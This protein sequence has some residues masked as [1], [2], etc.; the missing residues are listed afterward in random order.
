LSALC[1][2]FPA[3]LALI[4]LAV[5]P[6]GAQPPPPE[7]GGGPSAALEDDRHALELE[8]LR[9]Q[10]RTRGLEIE[11]QQRDASARRW[12]FGLLLCAAALAALAL[13]WRRQHARRLSELIQADPLTGLVN[14]RTIFERLE[15]LLA[16]LAEDRGDAA[17]LLIDLDNFRS[18]ND[19][20]GHPVG[21]VVLQSVGAALRAALRPGDEV[22]RLGGEEFM[23]VLPRTDA[24]SAMS[25][26]WRLHECLQDLPE[27]ADGGRS[28]SVTAS[29]GVASTRGR[30]TGVDALY[31]ATEEALL[32]AKDGGGNRC[33]LASPRA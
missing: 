8:L 20:Y 22:A 16:R 13:Y 9:E 19:R 30:P 18:V 26:A 24:A 4:V 17:V 25:V 32:R 27:R 33:E 10:A 5:V 7:S 21:D 28:I 2:F 3:L 23:I 11:L 14:R 15:A 29:I 6:A 12:A 31:R 1:R